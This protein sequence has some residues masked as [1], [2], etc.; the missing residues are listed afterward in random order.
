MTEEWTV[1]AG[2]P[3]GG[4]LVVTHARLYPMT[5]HPQRAAEVPVPIR[6]GSPFCL[7]VLEDAAVAVEAGRVV[8]VG[9]GCDLPAR[10]RRLPTWDADGRAVVPGFVDPH[11]HVPF[12]AWRAD[13][14]VARLGGETYVAQQG[15]GGALTGIPRSAAQVSQ[16]SDPGL[17]EFSAMRVAEALSTGTTALEMKSGYGLTVENEM[18]LLRTAR[19][20]ET[21]FGLP[22]AVTGLFLH[23]IPPGGNEADWTETVLTDLLPRAHAEGLLDAVDAF[24]EPVAFSRPSA[25]HLLAAARTL[26]LRTH[27]HLD[28]WTESGLVPW[29]CEAGV[30]SVDH[31]DRLSPSGISALAGSSTVAVLLPAATFLT[32]SGGGGNAHSVRDLLAA[33]AAVALGTDLNPGTAPVASLPET[34]ALGARMWGLGGEEALVMATVNAAAAIGV[35][36]GVGTIAVGGPGDFVVL[37]GESPDVLVYRLGHAAVTGVVHLGRWVRGSPAP[38]G[39]G[40]MGALEDGGPG[41]LGGVGERA[42]YA[43]PG[44]TPPTRPT[45]GRRRSR[46]A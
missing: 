19:R 36:G 23:A 22:G 5:E 10:L 27:L 2:W 1:H 42:R 18:R 33:G 16:A 26:G 13:E 29:A 34:M 41:D 6:G 4:H 46:D 44:S 25:A 32:G 3:H 39:R 21:Q 8:Y 11:T 43:D 40:A 30:T 20:L 35:G 9:P 38:D 28:Q 14:Y 24:I 12:A 17:F 31:L 7:P 37:D 45:D 15:R